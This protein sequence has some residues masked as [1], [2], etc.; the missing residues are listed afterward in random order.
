MVAICLRV[1]AVN[2][3]NR[4]YGRVVALNVAEYVAILRARVATIGS[5]ACCAGAMATVTLPVPVMTVESLIRSCASPSS[6]TSQYRVP[7]TPG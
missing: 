3:K 1:F 6:D 7:F 5:E 4:L 2:V